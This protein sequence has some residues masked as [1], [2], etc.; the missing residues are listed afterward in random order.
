M[1]FIADAYQRT[2][3]SLELYNK[4]GLATAGP[5]HHHLYTPLVLSKYQTIE[6]HK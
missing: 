6:K 4:T 5:N 1:A 2:G 3:F